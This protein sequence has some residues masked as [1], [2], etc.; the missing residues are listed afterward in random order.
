MAL[1]YTAT[2][3][4]WVDRRRCLE[5]AARLAELANQL[6]DVQ[7]CAHVK[8]LS[9]YLRFT[10]L[11]WRNEDAQACSM[12]VEAARQG[13]DPARLNLWLSRYSYFQTLSARYEEA[14]H[15]AE[16]A[17]GLALQS[18]STLEYLLA[19]FNW[20]GALLYLGEWGKMH[21][22]LEQGIEI[23]EKNGHHLG[24][25]L[26]RLGLASL[27]IETF[28]F[29]TAH[30]MAEQG[31]N[32]ARACGV[33]YGELLASLVIG[34]AHLGRAEP[35]LAFEHFH[36]MRA[37]LARERVVMDWILRI[38]LYCNL[39]EYWY[40]RADYV[41]AAPGKPGVCSSGAPGLPYLPGTRTPSAGAAGDS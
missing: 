13:H 12:A 9:A 26:H 18:G 2:T 10:W 24:L 19:T 28:D 20:A 36:S 23:A 32:Q 37:R 11:G 41:R 6:D 34:R 27:S 14:S 21:D 29:E 16:E 4:L 31:L 8:G 25:L 30:E 22:V 39:S 35:E 40:R 3:L 1:V 38:P 7:L 33:S 17:V 15:T 5:A